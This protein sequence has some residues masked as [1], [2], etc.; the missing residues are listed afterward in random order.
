MCCCSFSGNIC[1]LL[2][3]YAS[4]IHFQSSHEIEINS[5]VDYTNFIKAVDGGNPTDVEIDSS[6]VNVEK[7]GEYEVVY[8]YKDEKEF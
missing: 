3:L 7:L 6:Q 2:I 5:V 1:S 8:K 4:S